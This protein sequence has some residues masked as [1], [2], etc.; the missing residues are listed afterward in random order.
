MDEII[1]RVKSI[2]PDAI[3]VI[4]DY[5]IPT[6]YRI[7]KINNR[8]IEQIEDDYSSR[9]VIGESEISIDGAWENT[10]KHLTHSLLRKLE[11]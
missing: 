4:C 11:S 2:Y 10:W 3:A 6:L 9:F 7:V 1:L 8:T 5:N